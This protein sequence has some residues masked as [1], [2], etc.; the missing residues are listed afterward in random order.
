MPFQMKYDIEKNK[1][2]NY[3][4]FRNWHPDSMTSAVFGENISPKPIENMTS[5]Y[6]S[7]LRQEISLNA[8]FELLKN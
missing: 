7:C 4:Y 6:M 2:F 5:G 1:F 3:F 8:I